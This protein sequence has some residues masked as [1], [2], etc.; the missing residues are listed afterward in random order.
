MSEMALRTLKK[1]GLESICVANRTLEHAA[2]LAA[3][4]GATAHG[5]DEIEAL[6][7]DADVV[8]TSIGGNAPILTLDVVSR[9]L[10]DRRH[11][12]LFV[13]DIGVPRNAD[14]AIDQI[15]NLYRY[16]LDDLGSVANENAEQRAREAE[17]AMAI[18]I[19]ERQRFDGWFAALRAVPT[20]RHLR[21]RAEEIRS[22][23]LGRAVARLELGET[24]QA[25]V[26]A[27]TK[28]IVNKILHAP[29][30][31][32]KQ[33]A[34]REEGMAYLEVARVLFGLDDELNDE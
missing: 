16:D 28:S 22:R 20:I 5:L 3:E 1:N 13:I 19:E 24:E 7:A 17:R 14:P 6:L 2:V 10:R 31:R 25:A 21:D 4:F 15:D 8:I 30:S 12:P 33:E 26:D 29:V 27:L 23:E 18:V 34:E 11:R 9:A 32:L